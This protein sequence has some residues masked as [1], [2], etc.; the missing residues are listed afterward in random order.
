M[1][2]IQEYSIMDYYNPKIKKIMISKLKIKSRSLISNSL[3]F[4]GKKKD[5]KIEKLLGCKITDFKIYIESNFEPWMNWNNKGRYNGEFEF[6]WDIDHIKPL[7]SA[8]T[9][10]EI[11]KLNHYTNLVPLCSKINRD[12]KKDKTSFKLDEYI[13]STKIY[14]QIQ[15]LKDR[16]KIIEDNIAPEL[17]SF[18]IIESIYV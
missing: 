6:G 8:T 5:T 16:I 2:G 3:K 17:V 18:N 13:D 9:M 10:E 12:I 7:N 11:I 15:T 1:N 14:N 4:T